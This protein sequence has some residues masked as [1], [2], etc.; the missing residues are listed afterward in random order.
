[1]KIGD[2]VIYVN[3][4]NSSPFYTL[5]KHYIIYKID[6]NFIPGCT[7]GWI[8][9]DNRQSVY[10]RDTDNDKNWISLKE[11]RKQKLLKLSETSNT[12]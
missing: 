6:A 9:D 2:E 8:L 5:N 10:F 11:N 12:Y 4:S 1:M 3:E 7:C